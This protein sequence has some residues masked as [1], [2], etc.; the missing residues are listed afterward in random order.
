MVFSGTWP[1]IFPVLLRELVVRLKAIILFDPV[2]DGF[3][4]WND[5][6][7]RGVSGQ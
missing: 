1:D 5:N 4:V 7:E 3:A 6:S 2:I